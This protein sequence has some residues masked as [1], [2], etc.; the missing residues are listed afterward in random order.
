MNPDGDPIGFTACDPGHNAPEPSPT[1]MHDVLA[2]LELRTE[3]TVDAAKGHRDG[4]YAR[5]AAR[6]LLE[7]PGAAR[8][9]P[10]KEAHGVPVGKFS[11]S[12]Q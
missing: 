10:C 6:D 1:R 8:L 2:L 5:C 11:S 4:D 9:A 7:Q 12:L 3:L